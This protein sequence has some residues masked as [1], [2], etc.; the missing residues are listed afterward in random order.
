[1]IGLRIER[2][3]EGFILIPKTV[4]DLPKSNFKLFKMIIV[5]LL[6]DGSILDITDIHVYTGERIP[7]ISRFSKI[8]EDFEILGF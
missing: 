1:M 3:I 2:N 6:E 4:I 5:T 7:Q 8:S